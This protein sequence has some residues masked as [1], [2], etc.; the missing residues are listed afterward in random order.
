MQ[1]SR[2][3]VENLTNDELGKAE[4]NTELYEEAYCQERT[5][6]QFRFDD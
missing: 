3:L 6:C 1:P 2:L 4:Q 5:V